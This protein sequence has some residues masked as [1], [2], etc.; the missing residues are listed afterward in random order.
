MFINGREQSIMEKGVCKKGTT[1]GIKIKVFG[2]YFGNSKYE[3]TIS[4]EQWS[5]NMRHKHFWWE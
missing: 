4:K 2:C 1:V 3:I 5:A